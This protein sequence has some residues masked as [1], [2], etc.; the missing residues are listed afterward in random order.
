MNKDNIL[1]EIKNLTSEDLAGF[2]KA[3]KVTLAELKK[4]G[5]LNPDKR[6]KI[7][8]LLEEESKTDEKF[9]RNVDQNSIE[10]LEAYTREFPKG[11]FINESSERLNV[12][13]Q[14]QEEEKRKIEEEKE[15]LEKLRKER[16]A[17]LKSIRKAS[18]YEVKQ[19]LKDGVFTLKELQEYSG[20]PKKIIDKFDKPGISLDI[21][22]TNFTIPE[23]YT[24][25]Y[26]WGVPGSGKTTALGSILK[27]IDSMGGLNAQSGPG[28]RYMSQLK[29]IFKDEVAILPPP[30][31]F[32]FTQYLPFKFNKGKTSPVAFIELS[33]ETIR[34][35]NDVASDKTLNIDD[36][37]LYDKVMGYLKSELNKKIHFFFIDYDSANKEIIDGLTQSDLLQNS[38][39]VFEDNNIFS[40][41]TMAISIVITKSDL[42]QDGVD[43]VQEAKKHMEKDYNSFINTLKSACKDYK[44]NG[45]KL[46]Y[47]PFTIG[48]VYFGDYC[49]HNETSSK[50]IIKLIQSRLPKNRKWWHKF[51]NN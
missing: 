12:L 47:I 25:V 43:K 32:D 1:I 40:D 18:L 39:T 23:G 7:Q 26:F 11:I 22:D 35:F 36:Q 17:L 38:H 2:I 28:N 24:E 41:S 34:V 29:N 19:Y 44:L 21:R 48:D 51:L 16:L 50:S 31:Q 3:G 9:W 10:S 6:K 45:N 37:N 14:K 5:D 46:Q 8:E 33:G 30:T 27:T 15:R 13:R 20:V 42:M 49:I 4:T